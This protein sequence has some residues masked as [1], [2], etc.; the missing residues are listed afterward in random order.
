MKHPSF[1]GSICTIGAVHLDQEMILYDPT[2]SYIAEAACIN[3][4]RPDDPWYI[5]AMYAW[6][7]AF[8]PDSTAEVLCR[9]PF[10]CEGELIDSTWQKWMQ[11]DPL[12]RL[13]VYK[14]SLLKLNDIQMFIG[15]QDDLCGPTNETFHQALTDKSIDHGYET[16]NL[17]GHPIHEIT[18]YC[19]IIA[20]LCN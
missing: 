12:T 5:H 3:E 11:Y 1:L 14:D 10:T 13:D 16:Y 19:E 17:S 8:T 6:A 18:N 4:Y 7:E 15:N 20:R 2:K 9:L